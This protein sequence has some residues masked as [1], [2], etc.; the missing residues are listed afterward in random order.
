MIINK[1]WSWFWSLLKMMISIDKIEYYYCYTNR[2]AYIWITTTALKVKSWTTCTR[3][4]NILTS[5]I[6]SFM[7]INLILS[8]SSTYIYISFVVTT[9]VIVA[10][11]EIACIQIAI[12]DGF[13]LAILQHALRCL[14]L[15]PI[16]SFRCILIHHIY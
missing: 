2:G 14:R 12:P 10:S 9:K 3:L 13:V 1:D 4:T 15:F 6:K 16:G 11:F 5:F 8:R 7:F